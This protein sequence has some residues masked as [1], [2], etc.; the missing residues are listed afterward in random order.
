MTQGIRRNLW[1]V[2]VKKCIRRLA[3]YAGRDEFSH[4]L[5]DGIVDLLGSDQGKKEVRR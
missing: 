5:Y 4:T 2:R 1:R 3:C